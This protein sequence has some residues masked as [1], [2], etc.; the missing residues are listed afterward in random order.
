M[1][2]NE[3]ALRTDNTHYI[4]AVITKHEELDASTRADYS[5]AFRTAWLLGHKKAAAVIFERAGRC[6][7]IMRRYNEHLKMHRSILGELIWDAKFHPSH[8]NTI[9]AYLTCVGARD[10]VFEDV[11]LGGGSD[12]LRAL[13]ALQYALTYRPGYN[14][15]TGVDVLRILTKY[16]KHPTKH[17]AQTFGSRRDSLLHMVVLM[18]NHRAADHLL[19]LPGIDASYRNAQG[20]TAFDSCLNRWQDSSRNVSLAYTGELEAG[21]PEAEAMEHWETETL[22]LM[23]VMRRRGASKYGSISH[24]FKRLSQEELQVI[25]VGEDGELSFAK[26]SHQCTRN[27]PCTC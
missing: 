17:I 2:L 16:F 24:V 20:F 22:E 14:V 6:D 13:N 3:V 27:P 25:Q 18:G 11:V 26:G 23:D 8:V 15:S 9:D 4:N 10:A 21:V 1:I 7:V 19:Q 12:A 5:E